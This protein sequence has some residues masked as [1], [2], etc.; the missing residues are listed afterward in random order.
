M[1]PRTVFDAGD[2]RSWRNPS[3]P[4]EFIQPITGNTFQREALSQLVAGE[5]RW[6]AAILAGLTRSPS[7]S[8]ILQNQIEYGTG[9]VENI[10]RADLNPV[11]TARRIRETQRLNWVSPRKKSAREPAKTDVDCRTYPRLLKLSR[12]R[13]ESL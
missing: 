10:Q 11:E 4:M 5:S 8:A 2:S 6:R 1:Q 13:F 3:G 7:Y 12:L 9:L